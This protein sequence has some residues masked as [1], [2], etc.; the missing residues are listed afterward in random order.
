MQR[1]TGAT[2]K[3]PTQFIQY[4]TAPYQ[5]NNIGTTTIHIFRNYDSSI[6]F[7]YHMLRHQ[8]CN[9]NSNAATYNGN[10]IGKYSAKLNNEIPWL[11]QVFQTMFCKILRQ[12]FR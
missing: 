3:A 1:H 6:D 4:N 11:L 5:G 8:L 10:N 2:T 9:N 7:D 12:I